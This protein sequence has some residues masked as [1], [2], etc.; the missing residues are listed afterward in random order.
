[1]KYFEI[2][3]DEM[4]K[5]L[6]SISFDENDIHITFDIKSDITKIVDWANANTN[7]ADKTTIHVSLLHYDITVTMPIKSFLIFQD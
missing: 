2:M 4:P 6:I 3:A 1:M 5:G 7:N